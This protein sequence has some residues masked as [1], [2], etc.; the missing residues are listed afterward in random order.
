[1]PQ[2]VF[3]GSP[4]RPNELKNFNAFY[5]SYHGQED[6][7]PRVQALSSQI[8][9]ELATFV[10]QVSDW[11]YVYRR[12]EKGSDIIF[13]APY[14][15]PGLIECS[16]LFYDQEDRK[17]MYK[18]YILNALAMIDSPLDHAYAEMESAEGSYVVQAINKLDASVIGEAIRVLKNTYGIGETVWS[19][20]GNLTLDDIS[21]DTEIISMLSALGQEN[22]RVPIVRTLQIL[23]RFQYKHPDFTNS[24]DAFNEYE[25]LINTISS[26]VY[27]AHDEAMT[28]LLLRA[29]LN[30]SRDAQSRLNLFDAAYDYVKTNDEPNMDPAVKSA[31]DDLKNS[32]GKELDT[33]RT[34]FYTYLSNVSLEGAV[35]F[36]SKLN[37]AT[38][39]GVKKLIGKVATSAISSLYKNGSTTGLKLQSFYKAA[40]STKAL[41]T[42]TGVAFY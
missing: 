28:E 12:Y 16:F 9:E 23:K 18:Q 3:W 32:S 36:V 5:L 41:N 20:A 25:P 11:F 35:D 1:M 7:I 29:F 8:P 6:A 31:I 39:G 34:H 14:Y 30:T 4:E 15:R 2:G 37:D 27:N 40:S 24:I 33:V 21:G 13:T 10:T 17:D 22:I 26:S 42:F 38:N 19:G